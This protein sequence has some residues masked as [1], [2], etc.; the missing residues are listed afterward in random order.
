MSF[1]HL[2]RREFVTLLGGAAAL[3]QLTAHAQES[4]RIYRIGGLHQ[5]PHDAPQHLAFFAELQKL[6]FIEGQN[7]AVD[8]RG[9]GQAVERFAELAQ[10]Q[11]K[12]QLDAIICGGEAAARAVQQATAT[13]PLIVLVDDAIRA[14]LV[15]SLA[16][17]GGNTTGVSILATELDGK[18]QK[19][20]M[21]AVP[22]LRHMAALVDPGS[23]TIPQT[24]ALRGAA[25]VRGVELSIYELTKREDLAPAID[26][27]KA[28]GAAALNVLASALF[29]NNRQ[30]VFE[31]VAALRL[32]A[33]YQWPEMAEQEGL[34]GYGPRL[35]QLYRDVMSRQ[36]VKV[37]RGTKPADIP[38]EQ[39]T[40][41]ELVINLKTA[42][43]FGLEMPTS[44][45]LRATQVIE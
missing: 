39:P 13:I 10:D 24:Q 32:P 38:V 41:F 35:V 29:F 26:A 17:P 40:R 28:S 44:I 7:L 18:R 4:G 27:A 22:G 34:L 23:T 14:G 9:Y 31:R 20:L 1:D 36:V 30:I 42:R 21:E 25:R 2:N 11:V 15:R 8:R 5:S 45:L 12:V 3:A 33:I 16:K 6:G 19:I 37:L 43:A